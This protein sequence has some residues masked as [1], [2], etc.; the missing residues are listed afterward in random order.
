MKTPAI[1]ALLLAFTPFI[2][3]C[4][5]VSLWDRVFPTI[6]GLPFNLCWLIG[7]I[8]LTSLCLWGAYRIHHRSTGKNAAQ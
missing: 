7:W 6:F 4:F 3:I 1:G 8:P 2:A 5:S